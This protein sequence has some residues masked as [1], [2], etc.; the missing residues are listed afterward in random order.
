MCY[1]PADAIKDGLFVKIKSIQ[2]LG[3]PRIQ[4]GS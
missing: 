3:V 4:F 1:I 2:D